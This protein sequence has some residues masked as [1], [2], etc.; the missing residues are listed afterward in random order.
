MNKSQKPLPQHLTDFLDW[1][2][3]EKG[4][5]TKSQEN[6]SRFLKKFIDWLKENKLEDLKPHELSPAHIWNYRVYLS[7]HSKK[8]LKKSTQNYYLIGLRSLLNYFANRDIL[9][10]PSEK[11]KLARDRDERQVRFLDLE[12][13]EKLFS[14]PDV[15]KVSGLRDRAI[16][17]TL[18][19]TGMR[20]A[21]LVSLN[22][23]Q[24]K[25]KLDIE[26]LELSIVGKGRRIRTVYI[27]DRALHWLKKY[28]KTR[29]D[30]ERALFLNYRS[31]KGSSRRL[32]PRFIEKNLKKYLII[33]GLPL[34]TTP[35]VMRHSFSTDLL[36][37]GVDLRIL[38]EFL[39]HKSILA[40]QIYAHV[41]SKKLREI[42]QK[43]HS[44]KRL[45]K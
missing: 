12:Q 20:I 41:T 44:G 8:P 30:N 43:F 17:E 42:H 21:E 23:E 38:Q 6:Y 45:K 29:T 11:I 22:K 18:F 7:R 34:T 35:H 33:A 2:D 10:L 25:I 15:L 14:A 39:G 32:T 24:I 37:Q 13:L 26:E 16:L 3:I 31:R 9:S 19:S 28:L 5:S 40:T 27:S 4:L 36:N 1:L